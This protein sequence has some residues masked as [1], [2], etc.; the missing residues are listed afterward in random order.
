MPLDTRIALTGQPLQ[1]ESPV[2]Q[3]GQLMSLVN[4]GTQNQLAQMQISAAQRAQIEEED[5][6]NYL[7]KAD[8]STAEG[9][10]GLLPFGAKGQAI[11]KSLAEQRKLQTEE[12]KSK[13]DFHIKTLDRAISELTNL[14][15]LPSAF[16]SIDRQI[17]AKSITP[18]QGAELKTRINNAP[19]FSTWQNQTIT[20]MLDAKERLSAMEEQRY[21]AFLRKPTAAAPAAAA[22]PP[23]ATAT[24]PIND[25]RAALIPVPA[26]RSV[27]AIQL[28]DGNV[29]YRV[30]GKD[31]PFAVYADA[32]KGRNQAQGANAA[33]AATPG[34]APAAAAAPMAPAAAAA[35][36]PPAPAPA[37]P[38]MANALA[39]K[40]QGLQEQRNQLEPFL[41]SSSA[42]LKYEDLGKQIDNLS[43]GFSIAPDGTYVLPSVG[44]FK[45]AASLTPS[46]KE[47]AV[48][49]DPNSTETQKTNA[50]LQLA[51]LNHIPEKAMSDFERELAA[52]NLPETEKSKL[53]NAWLKSHSE[54]APAIS[55]SMPVA[56][57]NPARPGS[58]I[59]V[60]RAEAIGKTPATAI[61][62]LAPKEIQAREAKY[63][64]ALQ[65][66]K[67]LESKTEGLAK[68]IETL[69]NH[70]GLTGISGLVYGRTPAVTKDARAAQALYDSIV[71]R[72]GFAELQNMRAA[73]PTGGA[74]GNVSN[75]EGQ[76]LRDAWAAINRTQDTADLKANLIKAANQARESKARVKEA[77]DATYDYRASR[78][79]AA[80]ASQGAGGFKYL[81]K[82]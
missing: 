1:L 28:G 60:D 35:P 10:R 38:D 23:Q 19:D 29:V 31:V 62:G 32:V 71:A 40:I 12:D 3:Y 65:A 75:Q 22:L 15:D 64:Q 2:A 36:T 74:L 41:K 51:K 4:A 69:A 56:V 73:S 37:Q 58:V 53:R 70:P 17:A 21:Q 80:A 25:T 7:A 16:A 59:Y 52:S 77:F 48:L 46:Q 5:V 8:L 13:Y 26:E 81:G 43:K 44:T 76:Y 6:K 63:P 67:T 9:Q 79:A 20:G 45:G 50:R 54:H 24:V 47:Q 55:V 30:D 68:D 78:D 42:K 14:T 18:Q 57:E 39:L 27:N 34:M 72:G 61:E 33:I 66:V 49:D 11:L 82:E